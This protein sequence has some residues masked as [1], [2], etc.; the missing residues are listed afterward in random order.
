MSLYV[1]TNFSFNIFS[2]SSIEITLTFSNKSLY[3]YFLP[4]FFTK[5]LVANL[6]FI[7]I[8]SNSAI[9]FSSC[10]SSIFESPSKTCAMAF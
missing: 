1:F 5:P 3:P 2:R 7:T 8:S 4:R 9:P 6:S 10:F